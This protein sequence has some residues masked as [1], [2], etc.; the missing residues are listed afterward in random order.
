MRNFLRS[1]FIKTVGL[2]KDFLLNSFQFYKFK[3]PFSKYR[4]QYEDYLRPDAISRKVYGTDEYWWIILKVNPEFEDIWNDFATDYDSEI[5]FPDAFK[6]G[7]MINI[8]NILD[9]Q[10]FFT[11]NKQQLDKL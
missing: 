6:I 1:N 5:E 9:I 2:E 8:P 4:L 10:E 11:F 7:M 3:R